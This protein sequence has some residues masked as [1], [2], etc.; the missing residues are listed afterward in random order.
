MAGATTIRFGKAT[1]RLT[2]FDELFKR[3][4]RVGGDASVAAMEVFGGATK[5]V[6]AKSQSAVPVDE[7]NLKASGRISK[8]R[9]NTKTRVVTASVK[10]G[11]PKLKRLAPDEPVIYAIA[12][13]EDQGGRGFK[14]L[15]RP[16]LSEKSAVMGELHRRIAAKV[17]RGR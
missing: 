17:E 16:M 14:F 13:H 3:L 5:R 2:G 12:V 4:N 8:P 15:E 11:G 6:F 7:G 9:L 1:I 10:Y